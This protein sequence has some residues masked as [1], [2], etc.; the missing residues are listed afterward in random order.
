MN[1][2]EDILTG[3]VGCEAI[4]FATNAASAAEVV[5]TEVVQDLDIHLPTR[6]YLHFD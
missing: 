4:P 6:R 3:I 2:D 5:R 1:A